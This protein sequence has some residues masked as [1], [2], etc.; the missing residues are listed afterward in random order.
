MFENE[1]VRTIRL[2]G[3][4]GRLFGR[5]HRF[6]AS[7]MRDVMQALGA[8][9][10]GFDAYMAKAAERRQ[11]F[12]CLVGKRHLNEEDLS[13]EF[14]LDGDIRVAPIIQGNKRGGLFNI[15]LGAALIAVAVV[16]SIQ[17]GGTALAAFSSGGWIGTAAWMGAS[18]VLSGVV[19]A[20]SPTA[21]GLSTSDSPDNGA[22][23]AFNGPTNTEAQGN[24]V[25]I[26]YSDA[27]GFAW[28]GSAVVS[29][30]IFA[31]DKV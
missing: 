7:C 15:V 25:P 21:T 4:L 24:P 12:A 9:V 6:V 28:C 23:Y 11:G 19:Q 30:G 8:Q 10:A 20:I 31:E 2:Y 3:E 18:M 17:T 27:D 29:Q 22:S 26:V 5:T 1:T 16:A 13:R 14:P